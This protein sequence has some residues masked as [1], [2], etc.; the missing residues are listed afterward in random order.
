ML[1][2][3][4]ELRADLLRWMSR[5]D[6]PTERFTAY[7]MQVMLRS[8][9]GSL[10]ALGIRLKDMTE[11]GRHPT[12][13]ML[14]RALLEGLHKGDKAVAPLAIKNLEHEIVRLGHV[15][16]EKLVG[17]QI[18]Q[19][20]ALAR[21][22]KLLYRRF[23]TSARRYAGK[24]GEDLRFQLSVGVARG[25]TFEQL[26]QRLRRLAG[27][28]GP[29]AVR[30][31]LDHPNAIVEDIPEGLF[32]RY[33][34]WARRLV[35]TE[36]MNAYNDH[37]RAGITVLNE[38]RPK[39]AEEWVRRSDAAGD[40]RVCSL[41]RYLDGKIAKVGGTFPGGEPG[42]P[43]H[44]CCRCVELAWLMS[45]PEVGQISTSIKPAT[46][47]SSSGAHYHVD[48]TPSGPPKKPKDPR[49]VKAGEASGM[50]RREIYSAVKSNLSPDMQVAWDA[51]GHKYLQQQAGRIK[52]IKDPIN[53]ASKISE[54]F[55]ETYGS[56]E[57]T[58]FGNEGDRY[59]KRA[60]IEAAHAET[61][62]DRQERKYYEEMQRAA[63]A[64]GEIDEHGELTE[65][66]RSKLEREYAAPPSKTSDDDPPF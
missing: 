43:Y 60:E 7:Q 37:H 58:A 52:G 46:E 15:F 53:A 4:K 13:T 9:E 65:H 26:V 45:W 63:R 27:P 3:R 61:W 25:E 20:A 56:G 11:A 51:E 2:A 24:I 49:R 54:A 33:E 10:D 18:D 14:D 29:V 47:R 19:A 41:C 66:G 38:D 40:A 22:N 35:R 12:A 57:A 39:G 36:M 6:D 21:G 55:T 30:G 42:P 16:G 48:A 28:T 32:S 64:D 62:A 44:P 31:V 59:F 8:I 23:D 5:I 1:E 50:R 17:P 34:S